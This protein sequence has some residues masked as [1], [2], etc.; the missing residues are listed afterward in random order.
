M[1]QRL[2]LLVSLVLTSCA[3]E[4]APVVSAQSPALAGAPDSFADLLP[5]PNQL[6]E[7]LAPAERGS[8]VAGS[9]LL[10]EGQAFAGGLPNQRVAALASSAAFVPDWPGGAAPFSGLAFAMYEFETADYTGAATLRSAWVAPQPLPAEVYFGLADWDNNTWDWHPGEADDNLDLGSLEP[11][12]L[13][14][15]SLLVCVLKTGTA[16]SE[17]DWLRIGGDPPQASLS[18]TG[19]YGVYPLSVDFDASASTDA[20]GSIVNYAWDPEGDGSFDVTTNNSP[21]FSFE[22]GAAGDFQAAVRVTDDDGIYAQATVTVNA[23]DSLVFT[24]GTPTFRESARS[25]L[26]NSQHELLIF[27]E[28]QES[29]LM[30]IHVF[31]AKVSQ[32]LGSGSG[33][34]WAGASNDI[35]RKAVFGPDGFVYACGNTASYGE[36][37]GNGLLQKW[38]PDGEL[39]WSKAIGTVDD[40]VDF[41]A[42]AVHGGSIYVCGAYYLTAISHYLGLVCRLDLDGNLTWARSVIAPIHCLFNDLTVYEPQLPALPS[43]RLCGRYDP[44]AFGRDALY[45]EYDTDGNQLDCW[46]LG[47][48]PLLE[49]ANGICISDASTG[50]TSIV[51]TSYNG[52][53]GSTTN[54]VSTAAGSS[55]E[56]NFSGAN[57]AVQGIFSSGDA[58]LT[59]ALY[60]ESAGLSSILRCTLGSD[61]ALISSTALSEGAGGNCGL[62]GLSP[63]AAPHAGIAGFASGALPEAAS[64]SVSQQAYAMAWEQIAPSQGTPSQLVVTDTPIALTELADCSFNNPNNAEEAL[65]WITP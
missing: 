13:P 50:V 41:S 49:E 23:L 44:N 40:N 29:I 9:A 42:L 8:R 33:R 57:N 6:A 34:T 27:G 55:L 18:A 22:Y 59:L 43:L 47:S 61:L 17:L 31:A 3:Q 37:G 38:S 58:S 26:V 5:P 60:A 10:R 63:F 11:Y 25:V 64:L 2:L 12:L 45:A 35:L 1:L 65:V 54:F 28:R 62:A 30:P 53:S 56:V 16:S 32:D 21:L 51:G 20:D 15:G 39:V 48:D 4:A 7:H 46:I 24:Y 52:S 19:T 14:G 36:G